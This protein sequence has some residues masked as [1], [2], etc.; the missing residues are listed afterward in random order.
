MSNS[1]SGKAWPEPPD[2]LAACAALVAAVVV[3][4]VVSVVAESCR[5]IQARRGTASA[6]KK[7]PVHS[8]DAAETG[9]PSRHLGNDEL[10]V[11]L[12]SYLCPVS[13]VLAARTCGRWMVRGPP[14]V[15]VFCVLCGVSRSVFVL[16]VT[17]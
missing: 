17:V 1:A 9:S 16:C 12:T 10:S 13:Q 7:E 11:L 5:Q 3:W 15:S 14:F 2:T 6:R 8:P 4:Q